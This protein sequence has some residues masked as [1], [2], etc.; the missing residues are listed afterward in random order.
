MKY[1]P[2]PGKCPCCLAKGILMSALTNCNDVLFEE[3]GNIIVADFGI[4]RIRSHLAGRI[5]VHSYGQ[6]VMRVTP[7]ELEVIKPGRWINTLVAIRADLDG[8]FGR[9]AD[10]GHVH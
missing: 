9:I 5:S 8:R 4:V 10:Q 1:R 6:E 2:P 7:D 3:D